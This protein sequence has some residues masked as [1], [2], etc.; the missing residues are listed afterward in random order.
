MR[1][2]LMVALVGG[3]WCDQANCADPDGHTAWAVLEKAESIELFSLDP[4]FEDQNK[5]GYHGWK[6]LGKTT[7]KDMASRKKLVAT[8]GKG[9]D[10]SDGRGSKCLDPRH[11]IRVE[12]GNKTF[13]FVVCFQCS[14]V[15]IYL[16][17][18]Q[19]DIWYTTKSPQP[20]FDKIL[21]EAKV[22]LPPARDGR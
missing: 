7:I 21:K 19:I 6:I 13:D 22:P 20:E 14:Y 1:P 18:K 11:G 17:D 9:I 8:L 2:L 3:F 16:G 4:A 12:Q 5:D 10:D 15:H